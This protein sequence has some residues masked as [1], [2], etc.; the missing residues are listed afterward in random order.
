MGSGC[1]PVQGYWGMMLAV[2]LEWIADALFFADQNRQG[3]F[4]QKAK[5]IVA[6]LEQDRDAV[7][8]YFY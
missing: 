3:L 2:G 8:E 5:S 7:G 4:L 1:R 6:Y